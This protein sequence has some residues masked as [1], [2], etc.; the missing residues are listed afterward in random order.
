MAKLTTEYI[1][2]LLAKNSLRRVGPYLGAGKPL[3]CECLSCGR[4]VA[5]R[6]STLQSGSSGCKYCSANARGRSARIEESVA[7]EVMLA[8]GVKPLESYK[9]IA[10]RWLCVCLSCGEQVTPQFANV[11]AGHKACKYCAGK[12]IT[13]ER[14][15]NIYLEAGAKPIE[16]FPGVNEPW[17]GVCLSCASEVQPRL[18]DLQ[19]GQG[20]CRT[21]GYEKAGKSQK[22][23]AEFAYARMRDAG[24]EPLEDWESKRGVE[25]PWLAECQKCHRLVS[26][27][28]HSITAGQGACLFCGRDSASEKKRLSVDEAISSMITAGFEPL[29]P[30]PGAAESWYS[31]CMKCG[32]EKPRRLANIKSGYGCQE[33]AYQSAK[34]PADVA[35]EA[36][37]ARGFEPIAPY[38]S[39]S[40]KW[41][42]RCNTCGLESFKRL[43]SLNSEIQKGCTHCSVRELG[44]IVYLVENPELRSYKV[45][46]GKQRRIEDHLSRD[47]VLHKTWDLQTPAM[48]YKLE[49]EVLRYIRDIWGLPSFLGKPEMPQGGH[50]ETFS[51][52]EISVDMV[53]H[54]IQKLMPVAKDQ[55]HGQQS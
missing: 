51:A 45:G 8:A 30:Y 46:V 39:A 16:D 31:R 9:S 27:T 43:Y 23:S 53:T 11:R 40:E 12:A 33:C 7:V 21:C 37:R 18:T 5:P 26:P 29:A 2:E 4:E 47:W 44:A 24:V 50:T 20:A 1:D 3:A 34:I 36:M 19:R 52:D 17:H 42:C 10:S 38:V 25:D 54:L 28:L 48:A 32:S 14:A 13:K 49:S 55:K 15:T 6:V 22:L 41:L 35:I